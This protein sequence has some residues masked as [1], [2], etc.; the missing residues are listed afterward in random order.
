[1]RPQEV[2]YT[3][4]DMS[5]YRRLNSPGENPVNLRT[6]LLKQSAC[7]SCLHF[8]RSKFMFYQYNYL[9]CSLH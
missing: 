5:F 6:A 8:F 9:I 4:H 7:E 2:L 3:R 1:M